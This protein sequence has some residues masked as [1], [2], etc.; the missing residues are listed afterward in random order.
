L[1]LE[2]AGIEILNGPISEMIFNHCTTKIL[3]DEKL[4]KDELAIVTPW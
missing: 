2:E 1:E 3:S 4:I